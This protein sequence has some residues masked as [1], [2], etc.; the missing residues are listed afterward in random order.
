MARKVMQYYQI[1]LDGNPYEVIYSIDDVSRI[2]FEKFIWHRLEKIYVG[3]G[4]G[5][6][7]TYDHN[8]I[9]LSYMGGNTIMV[10]DNSCLDLMFHADGM[11]SYRVIAK[12]KKIEVHRRTIDNNCYVDVSQYFTDSFENQILIKTSVFGTD[13]WSFNMMGFSTKKARFYAD[14]NKLPSKICFKLENGNVF[15]LQGDSIEYYYIG[16][17]SGL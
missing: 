2:L 5:H 12:P 3:V 16:I 8:C 13:E 4:G 1:E 6:F 10:F 11:L 7:Y 15:Y 17:D 14:S 9:D